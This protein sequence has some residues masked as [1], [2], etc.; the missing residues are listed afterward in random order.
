MNKN[1]K[2]Q[3]VLSEKVN[4]SWFWLLLLGLL[5]VLLGAMGLGVTAGITLFSM[6]FFAVFVFMAGF[7]QLTDAWYSREWRVALWHIAVALLYLVAAALIS[8]DPILASTLITAFLAWVFIFIGVSRLIMLFSL[9]RAP[10]WGWMLLSALAAIV[11]GILILLKWPMSGVW[12]IG[13][14]IAIELIVSGWT[15]ILIALALRNMRSAGF[16]VSPKA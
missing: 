5:F 11:L 6:Y 1:I 2:H 9:Y 13:M 7:L 4:R 14:M 8:Y 3:N 10:G 15:Y 16:D 12:F